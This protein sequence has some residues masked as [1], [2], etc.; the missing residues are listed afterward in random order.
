MGYIK[1]IIDYFSDGG[2]KIF[3]I[4]G[5]FFYIKYITSMDNEKIIMHFSTIWPSINNYSSFKPYITLVF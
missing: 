3:N 4:F 2:R 1:D 5:N